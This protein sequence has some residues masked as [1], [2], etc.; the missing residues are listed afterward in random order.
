GDTVRIAGVA[1]TNAEREK[2]ILVLANRKDV[3]KVDDN[4]QV[5]QPRRANLGTAQQT[6]MASGG[7]TMAGGLGAQAQPR[8]P[9]PEETRFYRVQSG[10]TLSK[11]SQQFYGEPGKYMQ[12]FEANR[13]LIQDP[14]DIYPGQMLRVPPEQ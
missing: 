8:T 10:D 1:D 7:P 11:I 12:I 9:E 2:A 3:D 4:I 13:P 5:L 6:S 14:D